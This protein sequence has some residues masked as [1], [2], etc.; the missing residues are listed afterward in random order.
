[1]KARKQGRGKQLEE[2]S[3]LT[4]SNLLLIKSH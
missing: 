1:M 2:D 3:R 4:R